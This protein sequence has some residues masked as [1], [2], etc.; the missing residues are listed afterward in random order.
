MRLLAR[1]GRDP[2]HTPVAKVPGV[3][4]PR[5]NRTHAT[6][7]VGAAYPFRGGRHGGAEG[8]R[9]PVFTLPV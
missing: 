7:D 2:S 8:N 9:T 4:K 5:I 1:Q 6:M 3:I